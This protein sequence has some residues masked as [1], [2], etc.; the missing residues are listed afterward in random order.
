MFDT[1]K[2]K[3]AEAKM[4]ALMI[5][6]DDF[7]RSHPEL[8]QGPLPK[9]AEEVL[10]QSKRLHHKVERYG[11]ELASDP[12]FFDVMQQWMVDVVGCCS[13]ESCPTD[14][15]LKEVL[16]TLDFR[17]FISERSGIAAAVQ[18][19]V[20]SFDFVI[21]DS[22]GGAGG[23]HI[24]VPCNE[25]DCRKLCRLLHNRFG[26]AIKAGLIKVV[27]HFWQWRLPTLRNRDSLDRFRQAG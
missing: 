23:W 12:D 6:D 17:K 4:A 9:E 8:M 24:G 11:K 3:E 18:E 27:R 26:S 14:E 15:Q 5:A 22:G 13:E 2:Y 21:T 20:E 19:Y 7:L 25:N 16:G 10:E 1:P